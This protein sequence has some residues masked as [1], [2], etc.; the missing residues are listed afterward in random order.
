MRERENPFGDPADAGRPSLPGGTLGQA[1]PFLLLAASAA[2][3]AFR[4]GAIPDPY[5][6]HWS[7]EFVADGWSDKSV[8][9]VF[10]L[11]LFGGGL[12]AVM[13][14]VSLGLRFRART[15]GGPP[16]AV[17]AEWTRRWASLQI[18]WLANVL[19]G[20]MMGAVSLFPLFQTPAEIKLLLG[21]VLA[22]AVVGPLLL[23]VWI[24]LRVAPLYFG[25]AGTASAAG[26]AGQ[27]AVLASHAGGPEHWKLGLVYWNPE[28]PA[29]FVEK[30]IGIG[31][32]LNFARREVWA[33][34]GLMLAVPVLFLAWM[35]S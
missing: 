28:D 20:L 4:W 18:L 23:L 15:V 17:E 8:R 22:L 12:C 33:L 35:L 7:H 26:R 11:H 16:A 29:L 19:T 6:S 27:E 34:L 13:I 5:I 10:G 24:G 9:S 31:Y 3:L 1:V 25:R 21:A 32:T 30:H 14:L 2:Y